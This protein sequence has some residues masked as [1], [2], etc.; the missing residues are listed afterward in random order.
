MAS[1]RKYLAG[2]PYLDR[3]GAKFQRQIDLWFRM[4]RADLCA[5]GLTVALGFLVLLWFGRNTGSDS[6]RRDLALVVCGT[7]LGI[8]ANIVTSAIQRREAYRQGAY[9]ER[10]KVIR[11]LLEQVRNHR[12]TVLGIH[13]RRS[14]FKTVGEYHVALSVYGNGLLRTAF[15]ETVWIGSS[16]VNAFRKFNGLTGSDSA[17]ALAD[18]EDKAILIYNAAFDELADTLTAGLGFTVDGLGDTIA[19]AQTT[20]EH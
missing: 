18:T 16:G 17:F 15:T 1:E 5:V 8:A 7:L 19:E 2:T 20:E 6:I 3:E 13:S 14:S 10:A 12:S 11:E 4:Y 9:T